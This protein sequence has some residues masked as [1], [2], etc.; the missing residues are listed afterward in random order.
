M[1]RAR[2]AAKQL[3][4]VLMERL[5]EELDGG[6]PVDALT[7]CAD[8]AQDLTA[9]QEAQG[10]HI[11]RVS[12][13]TR[14]PA[15]APDPWEASQL[16]DLQAMHDRGELPDEVAVVTAGAGGDELRY[17][18]PITVLDP[19]LL[20]H[21]GEHDL[22]PGVVEEL[23]RRYPEDHATGY[24]AGDFRGAVSVRVALDPQK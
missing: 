7:V 18:K 15:N 8:E 19:C 14:N 23:S 2:A 4:G 13:R 9:A 1:E 20:C 17:L 10:L 24:A 16:D 12:L 6:S 11:R 5:A 21:G 3:A 22:D